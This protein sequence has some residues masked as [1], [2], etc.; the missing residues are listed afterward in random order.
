MTKKN[1]KNNELFSFIYL[2]IA[3][4]VPLNI[5]LLYILFRTYLSI[6]RVYILEANPGIRA[7][8]LYRMRYIN[9]LI[10]YLYASGFNIVFGLLGFA[11]YMLAHRQVQLFWSL[12]HLYSSIAVPHRLRWLLSLRN[13]DYQQVHRK[14]SNRDA[15]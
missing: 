3:V 8:N 7:L 6:Q 5:G 14:G 4:F 2:A 10:Y 11:V 9:S 12:R 1:R 13:T 15:R